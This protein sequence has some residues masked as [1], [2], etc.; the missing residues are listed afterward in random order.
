MLVRKMLGQYRW[1][2][3]SLMDANQRRDSARD[4][5]AARTFT[6]TRIDRLWPE[7]SGV[8]VGYPRHMELTAGTWT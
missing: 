3:T 7:E 6:C 2:T 5:I 8:T 1:R 4:S